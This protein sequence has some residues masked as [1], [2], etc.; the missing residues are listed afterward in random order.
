MKAS[1][2]YKL[3]PSPL[4]NTSSAKVLLSAPISGESDKPEFRT[5]SPDTGTIPVTR[6]PRRSSDPVKVQDPRFRMHSGR[7]S[8]FED[9]WVTAGTSPISPQR[10]WR[11]KCGLVSRSRVRSRSSSDADDPP[12]LDTSQQLETLELE[13]VK[14]QEEIGP[15]GVVVCVGRDT[16]DLDFAVP[17]PMGWNELD[18]DKDRTKID[19]KNLE[20]VKLKT[21]AVEDRAIKCIVKD[22]YDI[23]SHDSSTKSWASIERYKSSPDHE[24]PA[25]TLVNNRCEPS[26]INFLKSENISHLSADSQP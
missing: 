14:Q 12:H 22:V 18:A 1:D 5:S 16:S 7:R 21:P 19:S 4:R 25:D 23:E 17:I 24:D 11:F 9:R 15:D 2:R 3:P 26:S 10:V 13:R 8:H 6:V 20:Q